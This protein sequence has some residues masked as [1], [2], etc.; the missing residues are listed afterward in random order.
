M[1]SRETAQKLLLWFIQLA[2]ALLLKLK[3]IIFLNSISIHYSKN[4]LNWK[5]W[6]NGAFNFS[7]KNLEI[8]L[9][10]E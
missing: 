6:M 1:N 4:N 2:I 8:K 5:Q 7:M 3:I 10:M 9:N